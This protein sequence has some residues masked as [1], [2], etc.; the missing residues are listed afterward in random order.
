MPDEALRSRDRGTGITNLSWEQEQIAKNVTIQMT[1][2]DRVISRPVLLLVTVNYQSI[3][4][5]SRNLFE[6]K[7]NPPLEISKAKLVTKA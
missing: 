7:L 3:D 5:W 1:F 2:I 6:Q 4:E